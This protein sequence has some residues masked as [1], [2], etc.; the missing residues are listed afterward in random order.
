MNVHVDEA[1]LHHFNSR[2]R[3]SRGRRQLGEHVAL[4]S[5]NQIV[6]NVVQVHANDPNAQR[7]HSG[8]LHTH[9]LV[10]QSGD[11]QC[12]QRETNLQRERDAH[13]VLENALVDV[14]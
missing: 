7:Q 1:L 14:V 2:E 11:L 5:L 8:L 4:L 6:A 9:H 10:G 13:P 3:R 12:Q